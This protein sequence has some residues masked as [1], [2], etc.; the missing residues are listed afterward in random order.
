[1]S[2]LNP[3]QLIDLLPLKASD[4]VG[5]FGSGAGA[6]T[7]ALLEKLGSDGAIYAFDVYEP[8]IESLHKSC[9]QKKINNLFSLCV[10]LNSDIPLKNDVLQCSVIA[11]TLHALTNRDTFLSEL[12]RVTQSGGQV[13]VTDWM[14]SFNNLGPTDDV[15]VAPGEATRL[16][17][18]HGFTVGEM[19]PAGTHHWAFIAIKP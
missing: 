3:A 16:F 13:L 17:Q 1:M 5:D 2:F 9:V 8:H 15:V 18:A 12:N 11:N 19:L 14:H 4:K 7:D 10:D 6:Y